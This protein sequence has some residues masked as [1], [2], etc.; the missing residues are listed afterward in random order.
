MLNGGGGDGRSVSETKRTRRFTYVTF[1]AQRTSEWEQINSIS[2]QVTEKTTYS[3]Y[4]IGGILVYLAIGNW[5]IS[6]SCPLLH[7][8]LRV[9]GFPSHTQIS[10]IRPTRLQSNSGL[11][12]EAN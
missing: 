12:T 10:I 6:P 3:A 1:W 7:P 11:G 4:I 5:L 9:L 8:R 2:K